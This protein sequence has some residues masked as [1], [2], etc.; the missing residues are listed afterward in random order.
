[1]TLGD[2]GVNDL[3]AI[4]DGV[5]GTLGEFLVPLGNAGLLAAVDDVSILRCPW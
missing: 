3:G 4:G 2:V 1:M 5:L